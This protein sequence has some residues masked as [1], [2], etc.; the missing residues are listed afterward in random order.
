MN[1]IINVTLQHK[2]QLKLLKAKQILVWIAMQPMNKEV[3]ALRWKQTSK[4]H[5]TFIDVVA[6]SQAAKL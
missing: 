3:F 6:K 4:L 5:E 1:C 2:R